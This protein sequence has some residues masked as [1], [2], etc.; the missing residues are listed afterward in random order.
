MKLHI[1]F[2]LYCSLALLV[3]L[4][5]KDDGGL[6]P[7]V[8]AMYKTGEHITPLAEYTEENPRE[9]ENIADEHVPQARLTTDKGRE[10]IIIKAPLKKP[11]TAHYIEKIGILDETGREIISETIPRMP[12]PKTYAFF[13]TDY[14]PR[15]R[16]KLKI[17]IKCNLHDRWTVLLK[18]A[19]WSD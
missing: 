16:S 19:R 9:W 13:L 3:P 14:L 4:S 11:T 17:F 1:L 5:C 2:I 10:A 8:T 7:K 12:N 15:D 6:D 18:D